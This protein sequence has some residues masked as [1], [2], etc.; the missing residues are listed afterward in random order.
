MILEAPGNRVAREIMALGINLA[1]DEG[2][3]AA[4]CQN[5]GVKFLLK[6]ALKTD[7]ALLAKMVANLSHHKAVQV[8]AASVLPAV[9]QCRTCSRRLWS[10]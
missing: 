3:A 10:R 6:R 8:R 2:N 1:L 4:I 9:T 7:D 5:N